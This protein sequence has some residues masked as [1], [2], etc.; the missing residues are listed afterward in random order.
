MK[1]SFINIKT[2]LLATLAL[3]FWSCENDEKQ[4]V[5]TMNNLVWSDDFDGDVLDTSKWTYD[6]GTGANGWG[7]NELQ[8]YT[9][10]PENVKLENGMLVI[11][12]L[13]EA[14]QGAGYTSAR[15]NTKNLFTTQY[16]RVE[17]RMKL[18]WGKGMWPAFWMLGEDI[19]ENVW[20]NCG[21]IDIMENRGSEPT[22]IHGTVHGPGYF[23]AQGEGK[24]YEFSN[25][26]V[27]T[28]FHVY[29]IEWGANYI[30]FYVDDVLYN[31]ITVADVSGDWVFNKPF[32]MLINLAV[33][34]NYG[35]SPNDDT[36]FPQE[37]LVDYVRVY[38]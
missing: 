13:K 8:Y 35:G 27:D 5:T 6:I 9:N 19:D 36:V 20:P 14:Y 3:T 17:A 12:A 29:G 11:T 33:G 15:I 23:A 38:K 25:S 24:A 22:K 18:P 4:T 30:N 34:G 21:E 1:N 26:R 32:F 2:L 37:M 10:R 31:Q 16:G 28:E 7:N